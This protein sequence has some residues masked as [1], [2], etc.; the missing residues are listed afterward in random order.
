MSRIN[1]IF[2]LLCIPAWA[3]A[4]KPYTATGIHGHKPTDFD[5]VITDTLDQHFDGATPTLYAAQNGGYMSGNSGFGETA[6][7]QEFNVR[8]DSAYTV[9]GFIYWFGYKHTESTPDDSSSITLV[10]YDMDSSALINGLSRRVPKTL[11]ASKDILLPNLDTSVN[12]QNA[13]T[14]WNINPKYVNRNYA[15]GIRFDK[16]YFKDTVALYSSSDDDAPI[17]GR[18]WEYWQGAWNTI[19]F[20]WGLNV[21]FAIFPLVDFTNVGIATLPGLNASVKLYP[22]PSVDVLQ[23]EIL[24]QSMINEIAWNLVDLNGK[25]I[26]QGHTRNVSWKID[27][28]SLPQGMYILTLASGKGMGAYKFEVKK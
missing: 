18:S 10:F 3:S 9:E 19:D 11:I 5:K 12:F 16:L 14:I 2:L 6:K 27:V 21:D 24:S 23:V 13:M 28:A 25:I 22:N 7:I 15:P 17:T 20:N 4:Q 1:I 26:Q 8:I